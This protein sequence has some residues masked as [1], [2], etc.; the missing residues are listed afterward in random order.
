MKYVE[1]PVWLFIAV[2][3]ALVALFAVFLAR[4]RANRNEYDRDYQRVTSE[5]R[6]ERERVIDER[7][8]AIRERKELERERGILDRDRKLIEEL[9]RRVDKDE[10]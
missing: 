9:A 10:Q 2:L 6:Q 1:I 7:A 8:A 3:V 5:L 4:V